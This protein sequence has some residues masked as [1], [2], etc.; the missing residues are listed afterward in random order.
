[1][2]LHVVLIK[3]KQDSP[4][5]AVRELAAALAVLRENIPGILDYRWGANSS[6]E[7]MGRGYELGFA[8]TF[9]SAAARDAYLPHP[10]HRKIGPLMEP[11]AEEVLVFDIGEQR[12][13][14]DEQ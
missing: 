4:P 11:V 10:E 9:E 12:A 6:P 8:M 1:M 5:Q 3:P 7:G 14:R 2:V 13:M